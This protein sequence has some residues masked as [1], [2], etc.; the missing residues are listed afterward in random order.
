M[1]DAGH[2]LDSCGH[3]QDLELELTTAPSCACLAVQVHRGWMS[4]Q[5]V[6]SH[7]FSDANE[8]DTRLF[9][10]ADLHLLWLPS[11][12]ARPWPKQVFR[13]WQLPD[14]KSQEDHIKL[15]WMLVRRSVA[16]LCQGCFVGCS[17]PAACMCWATCGLICLVLFADITSS[18]SSG[19][20]A[21]GSPCH[22]N[23]SGP[24]SEKTLSRPSQREGR[25]DH[26]KKDKWKEILDFD[27]L[28]PK[29][30]RVQ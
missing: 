24:L 26:Y 16:V 10:N 13:G 25:K 29:E 23:N 1:S 20:R 27:L 7:P 8:A 12:F 4:P 3:N 18:G 5:E 22:Q 14:F 19:P 9:Q 11:D 21:V 17:W 30:A 2:I 28:Y 15:R 6:F